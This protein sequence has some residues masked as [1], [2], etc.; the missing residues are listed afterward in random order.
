M[1]KEKIGMTPVSW[2]LS[3]LGIL[4]FTSLIILPPVFRVVFKKEV[5]DEP[6]PV[7]KVEI[8][9]MICTRSNYTVEN[10]TETNTIKIT[11]AKDSLMKYSKNTQEEFRSTTAYEQEKQKQG[12]LT[13]AYSL[14][15]GVVYNVSVQDSNL[16]I[17][18]DENYNLDIFKDE[19]VTLPDGEEVVEIKNVYKKGDSANGIISELTNNGYNCQKD[20]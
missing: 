3:I 1:K 15:N 4:L 16:K 14:L 5:K 7:E 8:I 6:E 18:I 13:T 20:S 9:N 11:Y 17:I 12:K 2:L 10:H 19:N